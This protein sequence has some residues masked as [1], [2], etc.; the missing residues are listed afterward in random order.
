MRLSDNVIKSF[1]KNDRLFMFLAYV[2][3]TVFFLLNNFEVGTNM[4]DK[5]QYTLSSLF[6]SE[7]FKDYNREYS[8]ISDKLCEEYT[9]VTLLPESHCYFRSFYISQ[10][11]FQY[12]LISITNIVV[13]SLN[14]Y[15]D[16]NLNASFSINLSFILHLIALII[17]GYLIINGKLYDFNFLKISLAL[18]AIINV[19]LGGS[20]VQGISTD[21]FRQQNFFWY[22]PRAPGGLISFLSIIFFM[23]KKLKTGFLLYFLSLLFSMQFYLLFLF[24]IFFYSRKSFRKFP[25]KQ[26]CL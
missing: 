14:I 15:D 8:L 21:Y 19:D 4:D 13:S 23:Q 7:N 17:L 26:K 18:I 5:A 9:A 2:L 20:L 16:Y 3:L 11:W 10:N 24:L 12:P 1:N 25:A 6:Y 22:A